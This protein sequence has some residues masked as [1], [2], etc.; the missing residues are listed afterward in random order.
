M[1]KQS[2]AVGENLPDGGSV[3]ATPIS[4]TDSASSHSDGERT[5]EDDA[6][7][8]S[9]MIRKQRKEAVKA[10]KRERR[11]KRMGNAPESGRKPCDLCSKEVDLLVRGTI[12]SGPHCFIEPPPWVLLFLCRNKPSSEKS[13]RMRNVHSD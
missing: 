3:T 2:V 9:K 12:T 4:S 1:A 10:Q 8:T 11:A 5:P 6:T 7:L 13:V